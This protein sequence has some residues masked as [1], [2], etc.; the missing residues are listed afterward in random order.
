M[1]EAQE[2]PV[3]SYGTPEIIYSDVIPIKLYLTLKLIKDSW[4]PYN[5][6]LTDQ[7][8]TVTCT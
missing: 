8:D 6:D 1:R 2:K 5:N 3:W 7:S 4:S